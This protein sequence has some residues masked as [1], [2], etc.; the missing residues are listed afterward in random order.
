MAMII[1]GVRGQGEV[2]RFHLTGGLTDP[3]R[4]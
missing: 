2:A 4:N 3:Q 1:P